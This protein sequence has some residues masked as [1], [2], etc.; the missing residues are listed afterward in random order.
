MP[1]NASDP[2]AEL[3]RSAAAHF[4]A[5]EDE[6]RNSRDPEREFR[7]A[8]DD[9]NEAL[10]QSPSH[11]AA[12]RGRAVTLVKRA[13]GDLFFRRDTLERWDSGITALDAELDRDP[14]QLEL[15]LYRAEAR[16]CRARCELDHEHD[17]TPDAQKG[18]AD[19][20]AAVKL[21]GTC[22]EAYLRRGEARLVVAEFMARRQQHDALGQSELAVAD[23]VEAERRG[24]RELD[25][26][27]HR[28][29]AHRCHGVAREIREENPIASFDKAIAVLS[30]AIRLDPTRPAT[31]G[32][33]AIIQEFKAKALLRQR[34]D[35][36]PAWSDA[37]ADYSE[38]IRRAPSDVQAYV[39]RATARVYFSQLLAA[40]GR[41]PLPELANAIDDCDEALRLHPD[42]G[43]AYSV[44]AGTF[45]LQG[46]IEAQVG[47]NPRTSYER[48]LKEAEIALLRGV[49]TW[50]VLMTRA[51]SLQILEKR[52]EAARAYEELSK[53]PGLSPEVLLYIKEQI[54][55]LFDDEQ[56]PA[57]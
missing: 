51:Q 20:A 57:R 34:V 53:V 48:A 6:L 49:R 45:K 8:L 38:N 4:S 3:L 27:L 25:L 44:R 36:F 14:A 21:D 28:A 46:D 40:I 11:P 26:Y 35:P 37:I 39:H 15:L 42:F 22:G 55:R 13:G 10:L 19:G 23:F 32:E 12:L 2:L 29:M 31:Y 41:N 43:L 7:L 56:D 52:P 16:T 9:Y 24:Y 47:Q 1:N 18:I 30:E 5:A 50:S 17:P 54:K 33:R